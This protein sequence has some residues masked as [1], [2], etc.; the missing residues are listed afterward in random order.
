MANVKINGNLF[1][2]IK[3]I[4]VPTEVENTYAVYQH[5]YDGKNGEKQYLKSLIANGSQYIDTL[6]KVLCPSNNY[7]LCL[8]FADTG[9]NKVMVVMGE[10]NDKITD[11]QFVK[12]GTIH[13]F[14]RVSQSTFNTN[15]TIGKV[16]EY[17]EVNGI[18]YFDNEVIGEVQEKF[19]NREEYD[20]Y[21]M[22]LFGK[23]NK[24]TVETNTT[25][26]GEIIEFYYKVEDEEIIHLY[27]VLDE[28][29][30]PCM[31]D[32]VKDICLYNNG[33]VQFGYKTQNGATIEPV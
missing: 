14:D 31:Y 23:N 30:V 32:S 28:D 11:S 29:G 17:K 24:G 12:N 15:I 4:Q 6:T 27:P 9:V 3:Y 19:L 13:R 2:G 18:L 10:E 8:K 21:D 5:I 16:Y 22:F 33:T 7:E 20:T 1:S 25:F 26:N